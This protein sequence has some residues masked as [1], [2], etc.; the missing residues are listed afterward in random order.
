MEG[1][2]KDNGG[3]MRICLNFASTSVCF[4]PRVVG[5]RRE[6]NEK[7]MSMTTY[8]LCRRGCDKKYEYKE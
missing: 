7:Y 8:I 4:G 1:M 2:F 3:G 6:L 5:S